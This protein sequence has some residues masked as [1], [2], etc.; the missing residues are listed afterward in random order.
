M[1]GRRVRLGI[2][3]CPNDTFAFHGLLTGAVRPSGFELQIELADI[4]ALNR[5]FEAGH[6]DAS[7]AS[8][9]A[10]LGW[11]ASSVVL[12]AGSALGFG[13]GPLL[14]ARKGAAPLRDSAGRDA[15]RVLCPGERTTAH[16]LYRL[17][18][19]GEGRI[20]QTVFSDILP[21]LERGD[22][23]YGVCIHEGR[24]TY[25]RHGLVLVEDLG[26]TWERRMDAPLPLGGIVARRELGP[27]VLASLDAAIRASL[28]LARAEPGA[29]LATMRAHAQE[30][31]DDVIRAHVDLYVNA[32]T[33]DL[34]ASGLRALS[35]LARAARSAGLVADHLPALEV[36]PEGAP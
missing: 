21:A 20:E 16:L 23:D 22:A 26:A 3:P 24:F 11:G 15:P 31:D 7:K 18:H 17:F 28:D 2:S 6:T 19:A 35:A 1:S 9:A 27:E 25:A 14:L 13:V 33:R 4:E 5:R 34:G 29:A 36:A 10:A 8:F 30:L 12:R 32:W